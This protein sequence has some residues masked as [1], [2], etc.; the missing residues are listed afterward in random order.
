MGVPEAVEL[1]VHNVDPYISQ[2]GQHTPVEESR[3]QRLLS[4]MSTKY[5]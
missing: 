4:Q 3:G 5:A 1:C 2:K